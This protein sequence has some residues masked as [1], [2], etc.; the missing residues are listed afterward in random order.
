MSYQVKNKGKEGI[1]FTNWSKTYSCCPELVFVPDSLDDLKEIL[2]LAHL[3]NKK[4]RVVGCGH[5]PS[6]LACTSGYL[7]NLKNFNRVLQVNKEQRTVKVEGGITITDMN[8]ELAKHGLALSVTGSVSDLTLAGAISTGTHGS[9]LK[10]GTLSTYVISLEILA[11]S[12]VIIEVSKATDIQLYLAACCGL[13][14]FGIILT[15]TYQCERSFLLELN[16]YACPLK[17]VLENIEVHLKSSDYFRFLWFPHTDGTVV[18]HVCRTKKKVTKQRW[19]SRW[20]SWFWDYFVGYYVLEFCYWISTFL[21]TVVPVINRTMYR[22]L[23]CKAKHRVD[24]S[25]KIFN[26]ECL[27]KQY[28]T[29]WAVPI[30]R[31]AIVLYELQEW[32]AKNKFYAHFPVE[33]R[34]VKGDSLLISPAMGRD[35]C[36]IN[37]I[38]YRPYNKFV[39]YDKYWTAFEDIMMRHEGR[40]HWAK[41][42]NVTSAQ[43]NLM[44]PFFSRWRQLRKREDP[45]DT[46]VNG[47]LERIL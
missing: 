22:M 32:I 13:G 24:T 17:Q 28:V 35:S 19:L 12:G 21:P 16:Q 26:F 23:C 29:E 31:T 1:R 2:H 5:S 36:F 34:F 15:I 25:Y 39:P 30:E 14:A 9:G 45:T 4:V 20:H 40:P 44:Y 8:H 42:H 6:D 27:F 37:I 46:F 38:M 33:V 7:V 47:Y 43:F 41:A 18:Y 3:E 10:Y 11:S